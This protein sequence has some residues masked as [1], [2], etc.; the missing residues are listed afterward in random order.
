MKTP[1]KG[2]YGTVLGFAFSV[3]LAGSNA[4]IAADKYGTADEA[5]AMI[6]QAV[7][8]MKQNPTA[9]L[10]GFTSCAHPKGCAPG[11]EQFRDRDLYVHCN[12]PVGPDS[13]VLAHGVAPAQLIGRQ[14]ASFIDKKGHAF[15]Q[16]I[17]DNAKADAFNTV[18]YMWPR[19]GEEEPTKKINYVTLID[20]IICAVGF[21]A[22]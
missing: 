14:T 15:G 6:E 10:A 2:I 5:K 16:A 8:K 20:D 21:Y 9:A 13:T 19:P 4:S 7:V 1:L 17:L 18:E 12:G 22:Q 3:L 11:F